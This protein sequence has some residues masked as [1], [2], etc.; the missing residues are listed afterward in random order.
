MNKYRYSISS[1]NNSKYNITKTGVFYVHKEG[2]SH[3]IGK[4]IDSTNMEKPVAI[5]RWKEDSIKYVYVLSVGVL[6]VI[7]VHNPKL[8][9]L[10]GTIHHDI[11][12]NA[13]NI[14]TKGVHVIAESHEGIPIAKIN[15]SDPTALILG[16][17]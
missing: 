1:F 6:A 3:P 2:I 8:P 12:K 5:C 7:S 11:L 15:V 16:I 13:V 17:L 4:L 14:H 10:V 9:C